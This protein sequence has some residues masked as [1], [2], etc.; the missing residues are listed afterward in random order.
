MTD[1]EQLHVTAQ[2]LGLALSEDDLHAIND[3]ITVVRT[4]LARNRDDARARPHALREPRDQYHRGVRLVSDEAAEHRCD[5]RADRTAEVRTPSEIDAYEADRA[6][7][8]KRQQR[9]RA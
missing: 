1:V 3:R 2:A 8:G 5:R 9:Q 4:V 6:E 7:R